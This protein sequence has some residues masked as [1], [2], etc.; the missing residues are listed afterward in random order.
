MAIR[1]VISRSIEDSTIATADLANS[2][3]TD[4]KI[5]AGSGGAGAFQGDNNSGAL[6]GDTTNGKK[7]IFRV[8]ETTL[9]TSVTIA[10]GD[11]ALAAGPLTVSTTG[12]VEL[13]VLGNLTIV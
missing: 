2:A 4:A 10:S 13:K 3:V 1:K 9:N 8:H 7:D 11:N 6:N 5:A 12:T